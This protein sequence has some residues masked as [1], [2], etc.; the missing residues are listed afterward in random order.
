VRF[1]YRLSRGRD[2]RVSAECVE[3]EVVG[4]GPTEDAAVASLL[5]LL[6]ERMFRPDA[7]APPSHE[8][9]CAIELVRSGAEGEGHH[10]R[11]QSMR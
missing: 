1:S 11:R 5:G 7:V 3:T 10:R 2:G 6:E 8:P 4:E 9:E